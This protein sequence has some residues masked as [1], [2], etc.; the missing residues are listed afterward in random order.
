MTLRFG[1]TI[2]ISI[3]PSFWVLCAVLG[4]FLAP[5]NGEILIWVAAIV[6]SLLFHELGHA[7]I[8]RRYGLHARI[9]L[10]GFGGLTFH[11]GKTLSWWGECAVA[12]GG[13]L[14]SLLLF[15]LGGISEEIFEVGNRNLLVLVTAFM[16]INFFWTLLNFLPILPLDLGALIV[17]FCERLWGLAGR[18]L[19][20]SLSLATA[21]VMAT[22]VF[23]SGAPK[24]ALLFLTFAA[25]NLW[26]LTHALWQKEEDSS[27]TLQT[28][29]KEA[30]I[31]YKN[32]K[33]ENGDKALIDLRA[34]T[35][36]GLLHL[37][38]TK[39]LAQSY[40]E[41]SKAAEATHLL[42]KSELWLDSDGLELLHHAAYKAGKFQLCTTLSME[43]FDNF[44][45]ADICLRNAFAN[46]QQGR[47]RAAVGWLQ[48]STTVG[49]T[50]DLKLLHREELDPIRNTH[51]FQHFA[52]SWIS[53]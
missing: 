46:S 5:T 17:R 47:A 23:N 44:R 22:I 9:E 42:E 21:L 38:A 25:E 40:L 13:P 7:F 33:T 28:I 37:S 4:Y 1:K 45:N 39:R 32:G 2:P 3:H 26:E 50:K 8:A 24:Y 29:L 15:F 18:R 35:C 19:A 36:H 10:V 48:A 34:Q 6:A 41:Q 30:E 49:Q 51:A 27:P 11:H 12:L 31:H 16:Y 14:A 20:I 53:P 52:K 43:V